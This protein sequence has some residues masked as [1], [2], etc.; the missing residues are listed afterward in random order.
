MGKKQKYR[1]LCIRKEAG[2]SSKQRVPGSFVAR[3]KAFRPTHAVFATARIRASLPRFRR[4]SCPGRRVKSLSLFK[5]SSARPLCLCVCVCVCVAH[6]R[7]CLVVYVLAP[8]SAVESEESERAS[9]S[10]GFVEFR[11]ANPAA[12]NILTIPSTRVYSKPSS[13]RVSRRGLMKKCVIQK[14][15]TLNGGSLGSWID[16]E[17]SKVR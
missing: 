14:Y 5:P 13:A 7:R 15:M 16:E 11:P 17:R 10:A 8:R 4:H 6:S 1:W 12:K 9:P 3:F 2:R